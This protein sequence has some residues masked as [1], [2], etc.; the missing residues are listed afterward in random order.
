LFAAVVLVALFSVASAEPEPSSSGVS[1]VNAAGGE[2][3]T[4]AKTPNDKAAKKAAKKAAR[5]AK[6]EKMSKNDRTAWKAARAAR[7][8]KRMQKSTTQTSN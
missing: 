8:A 1:S 3:K 4:N 6:L 7:I 2:Q 5:K